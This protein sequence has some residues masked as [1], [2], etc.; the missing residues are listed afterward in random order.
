MAH[1]DQEPERINGFC[2]VWE[3]TSIRFQ[4]GPDRLASDWPPVVDRSE[5]HLLLWA[6]AQ[7]RSPV[8]AWCDDTP[9][10]TQLLGRAAAEGLADS[11]L[12]RS[13][14]PIL[15]QSQIHEL[16]GRVH[17]QVSLAAQSVCPEDTTELLGLVIG[18][19]PSDQVRLRTGPAGRVL[20]HLGHAWYP[21]EG[22]E[23]RGLP[24]DEFLNRLE[25]VSMEAFSEIVYGSAARNLLQS[26][27]GIG[28][29][30]GD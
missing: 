4:L 24:T 18:Q 29:E 5:E 9:F 10:V 12:F 16:Q 8:T 15:F 19:Q 25:A 30:A 28:D 22:D 14:V 13:S 26:I 23:L 1:L 7:G 3:P 20:L 6:G 17:L 2:R 27:D 21:L 11:G